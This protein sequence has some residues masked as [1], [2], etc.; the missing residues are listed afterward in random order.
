MLTVAFHARKGGVG[1]S[2]GAVHLATS[3][4]RRRK[5]VALIDLDDPQRSCL[6]WSKRRVEHGG[7]PPVTV[8]DARPGDLPRLLATA[9]QQG[10]D[11]VILDTAGQAGVGEAQSIAAAD[12]VLV[13]CR[14]STFDMDAS[15]ATATEIKRAGR[16]GFFLLSAAPRGRKRIEQAR[17]LLSP[18]LP[19]AP[20]V[21]HEYA[22]YRDALPDGRSVEELDPD[23]NAAAEIRSLYRWI[24]EVSHA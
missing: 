17:K 9:R 24:M 5:V 8:V 14:P 19:V 3:A 13:P 7:K 18:L 4:A 2:T 6:G 12:L 1:K 10:A 15:V 16:R 20:V 11:L 23:G 22:A 21:I